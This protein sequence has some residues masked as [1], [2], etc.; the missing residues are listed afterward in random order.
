[1]EE[2]KIIGHC[3]FCGETKE[4]IPATDNRNICADCAIEL[5]DRVEGHFLPVTKNNENVKDNRSC[6]QLVT[7]ATEN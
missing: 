5:Q 2:I 3:N 6:Q 1:M 7:A 4:V